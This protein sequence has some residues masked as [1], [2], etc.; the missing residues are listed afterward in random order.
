MT[1]IFKALPVFL[2]AL[3]LTACA[4]A[5]TW[6]GMTESEIAGWKGINVDVASAQKFRKAKM[7]SS[8]VEAWQS[9]GLGATQAILDWNS[10]GYTPTTGAP[11]IGKGFDLKTARAWT[12]DKFTAQEA[13]AWMDADFTLKEAVKNRNKGLTPVR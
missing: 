13:R 3:L 11:W 9:A 6:E 1:S 8:T 7:S 5:P 12:A 4:S 2:A 10:A